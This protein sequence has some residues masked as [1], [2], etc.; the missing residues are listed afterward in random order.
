[1]S[2]KIDPREVLGYLNELGYKNI[3]AQQLKDFIK[4][5]QKII[6]YETRYGDS[7][8]EASFH[9]LGYQKNNFSD[10]ENQHAIENTIYTAEQSQD[11][12]KDYDT[13][14]K[15]RNTEKYISVHILNRKNPPL[16]HEHCV[17]IKGTDTTNK[18][19]YHMQIVNHDKV[20]SYE[21]HTKS[22]TKRSSVDTVPPYTNSL[23]QPSF[24]SSGTKKSKVTCK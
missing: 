19:I 2:V 17:H 10:K 4:D 13:C 24:V 1:M 3:T 20:N 23:I 18:D 7:I 14:K 8:N 12:I 16:D 6:K 11:I 15:T 5:L 9:Q 21:N 22:F